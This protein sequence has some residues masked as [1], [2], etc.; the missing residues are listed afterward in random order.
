MKLPFLVAYGAWVWKVI[1]LLTALIGLFVA[2][3][4]RASAER[5]RTRRDHARRMAGVTAPVLAKAEGPACVTGTL[6]GG[7]AT[8]LELGGAAYHDRTGELW[9][10]V[11]GERLELG[12]PVHVAYG[13]SA[14][15]SRTLPRTT[16]RGIRDAMARAAD[17]GSRVSKMLLRVA[18]GRVHRLARVQ[19]GDMVIVRGTLA[20]QSSGV[21]RFG[22][23]SW[24]LQAPPDRQEIELA[25]V[26]P[27][28]KAVPVGSLAALLIAA[29]IGSAACGG[30]YA[31]GS[32]E[33]AV[34]REKTGE[35]SAF[36]PLAIAAA[37]PFTRTA[38]LAAIAERQPSLRPKLDELR[39]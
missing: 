3:I 29:V 1:A 11:K 22:V 23:R 34:G 27:A 28:S 33:L 20:G 13:T 35:L 7:M 38:A 39:K 8:T 19:D 17:G 16:P 9:V 37:M 24:I 4:I 26:A 25:A 6:H 31:F 2:D 12:G 32:H 14:S 15:A 18:G 10:D 5:A 36:D 30:M 21:D